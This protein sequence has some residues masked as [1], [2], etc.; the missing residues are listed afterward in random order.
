ME[1]KRSKLQWLACMLVAALMVTMAAPAISV[2]AEDDVAGETPT[3]E[4]DL[5]DE[6]EGGQNGSKNSLGIV[7]GTKNTPSANTTVIKSQEV[8]AST[9][10]KATEV[11]NTWNNY[12]G[13]NQT[14]INPIKG[15]VDNNRI[16]SWDGTRSI[17][18]GSHEMNSLNTTKAHYHQEQWVYN[19]DNDTMTYYNTLVRIE[20]K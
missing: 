19:Q 10:V 3:T 15:T 14:V 18:F 16:F 2:K 7:A 6:G 9:Q 8:K 20:K 12:L 13:S 17:R 1:K 4:K 11:V 5:I